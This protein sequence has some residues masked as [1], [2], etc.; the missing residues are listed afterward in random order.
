[1]SAVY[2]DDKKAENVSRETFL[3]DNYNKTGP[4]L[5]AQTE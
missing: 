4:F 5:F 2:T 1:L 3:G